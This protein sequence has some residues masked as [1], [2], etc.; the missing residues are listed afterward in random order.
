MLAENLQ[1][2]GKRIWTQ[3]TKIVTIVIN[4]QKGSKPCDGSDTGTIVILEMIQTQIL[5]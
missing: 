2:R 1:D 4:T 3:R 5:K